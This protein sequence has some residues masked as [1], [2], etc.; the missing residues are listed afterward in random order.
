MSQAK[1]MEQY[2]ENTIG[3]YTADDT[4]APQWVR[5]TKQDLTMQRVNRSVPVRIDLEQPDSNS[6]DPSE[7][8]T[9]ED[10]S[11]LLVTNPMERSFPMGL[12]VIK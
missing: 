6:Y 11:Q 1:A 4:P 2:I 10:G 7:I 12:S 9:F 8:W 5:F 3:R